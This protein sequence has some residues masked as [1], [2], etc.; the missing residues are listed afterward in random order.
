MATRSAEYPATP[1]SVA[2]ARRLVLDAVAVYGLRDLD[3]R[4]ALL[5][6]EL[7]TN[8]VTH[9]RGPVGVRA[10][11]P[12]ART[13]AVT[14]CDKEAALP[15]V[16]RGDRLDDRGRGLQIVDAISDRWGV[17]TRRQ[18]KCVWFE[19]TSGDAPSEEMANSDGHPSTTS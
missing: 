17:V 12:S 13:I 14:V 4:A 10:S 3:D 7:V 1:S 18:G 11:R 19:L 8:A 15:K 6:S 5:A 16:E 2:L 9:S